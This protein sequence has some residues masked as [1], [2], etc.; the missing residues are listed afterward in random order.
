MT[1][2]GCGYKWTCRALTT[3][4]LLHSNFQDQRKATLCPESSEKPSPLGQEGIT[5][6]TPQNLAIVKHKEKIIITGTEPQAHTPNQGDS[7]E[8]GN[9]EWKERE[10][11][12]LVGSNSGLWRTDNTRVRSHE[13]AGSALVKKISA[14]LA[15]IVWPRNGWLTISKTARVLGWIFPSLH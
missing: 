2:Q 11:N 8:K 12:A 9:L 14:T 1:N 10:R 5:V 3:S 13:L 7:N 15:Q 4:K 6:S